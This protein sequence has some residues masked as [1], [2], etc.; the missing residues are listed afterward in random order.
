MV[1]G[2][3]GGRELSTIAGISSMTSSSSLGTTQITIQFDLGRNI[4]GASLDVQT[5]LA[6]AQ[7]RLPVEMTTPPS[8]RKVNPG[9]F[10]VIF[11]S[12]RSDT[13]PLSTLNE[14]AETILA[15][16]FSQLSGVAQVSVFGAQRFAVRVQVDPV[17]AAKVAIDFAKTNDKLEI[18]GGAMG[19]QV[20]NPEGIKALASRPSLDEMRGT[21]IGLIQAPA[22]K[23]AQL[24]VAPASKLARVFNAYAEKDAEAA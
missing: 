22:T 14:Y 4:D 8:F 17:A 21:L 11:V 5:A 24:V 10:A 15:P 9:D 20:L 1:T 7:R 3:F 16:T 6:T 13:L 2:A 19:T 12:L 23:I 18:V